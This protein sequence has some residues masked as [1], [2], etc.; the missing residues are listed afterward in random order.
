MPGL[1]ICT[2]SLRGNDR[3]GEWVEAANDGSSSVALTGL[4]LT[5]YTATQRHVHIYTFPP[6]ANGAPLRLAPGQTAFVFTGPGRSE[7]LSDGNLLLF[8]GRAQP[9]WNNN[10]DVAYL[11]RS[12]GTFIDTMT[13][14]YPKRHPNG[15]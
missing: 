9:V 1:H 11:R 14:G 7:R 15:H 12:D 10:G 5:D 4:K 6:A 13:V 2:V 8:A 3:R